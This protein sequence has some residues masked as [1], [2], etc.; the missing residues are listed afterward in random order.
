MLKTSIKKDGAGETSSY[1]RKPNEQAN[2]TGKNALRAGAE[3]SPRRLN[4][5]PSVQFNA[6]VVF[7]F[8]LKLL[9]KATKTF[10]ESIM[11]DHVRFSEAKVRKKVNS[12]CILQC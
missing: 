1:R 5:K 6:V 7:F 3:K 2:N 11:T 10:K 9:K 8:M 4:D 12:E